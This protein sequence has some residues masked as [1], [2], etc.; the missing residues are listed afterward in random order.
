LHNRDHG[1]PIEEASERALFC[2]RRRFD[3]LRGHRRHFGWRVGGDFVGTIGAAASNHG[4]VGSWSG[5]R[6]GYSSRRDG[7]AAY[8]NCLLDDA[9]FHFGGAVVNRIGGATR[10]FVRSEIIVCTGQER[11][12]SAAVTGSSGIDAHGRSEI[13]LSVRRLRL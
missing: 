2:K 9:G 7:F 13:A 11:V 5:K 3:S 10:G 4:H 12:S 1:T 6:C 8:K